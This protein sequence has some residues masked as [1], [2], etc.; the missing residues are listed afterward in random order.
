MPRGKQYKKKK[1]NDHS[2][3]DSRPGMN[4]KLTSN[5]TGLLGATLGLPGADVRPFGNANYST[6]ICVRDLSLI[7]DLH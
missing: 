2:S 5:T 6:E 3:S 7:K 4:S 1:R